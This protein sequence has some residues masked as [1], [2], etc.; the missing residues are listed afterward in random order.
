MAPRRVLRDVVYGEV[1]GFRPLTLDIH[2]PESEP[3][4]VILFVHGGGWRAGSKAHFGPYLTEA[5]TFERI[6]DAGFAVVSVDYRLSGEAHFPAQVDD[7][8]SALN[9]VRTSGAS[10][11]IDPSRIVLWGESAGAT[12]ASLVALEPASGVL[13]VIDW[14]GPSNLISMAAGLSPEE[15]AVTRETGW[16]GASAVDDPALATAASPVFAVAEGAPPFHIEHGD[17][18]QAVPFAQSEEFA[19]ALAATGATVSFVTVAGGN[20]MWG[21]VDDTA[22]IVGRAIDF[23]RSL[24]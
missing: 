10:L 8:R 9:W 21:G 22:P 14:Y 7:V 17:S 23:A 11:G 20:H 3:A 5:Q 4:P 24:V 1:L 18:D 15:L 12:L 13:G 19:A 16:L 6:T 2:L